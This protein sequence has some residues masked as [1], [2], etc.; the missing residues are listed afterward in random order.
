MQKTNKIYFLTI[1]LAS[2]LVISCTTTTPADTYSSELK[3]FSSEK[4]L[5]EFLKSSDYGGGY[6]GGIRTFAETAVDEAVSIAVPQAKAGGET[7]EDYSETNIQ[8]EG[9]DEA[10]IVKNDG[11]YIYVLTKNKIAIVDAYPA[12]DAEL[13]SEIEIKGNPR[14]FFI[15]KDKLIIFG[16][17]Y[18][19]QSRPVPFAEGIAVEK[20]AVEEDE[21][22]KLIPFPDY[23]SQ[24]AYAIIY[25]ISDKESPEEEEKII[26]RGNYYNSRMIGDT[27]YMIT[28]EYA[29]YR[30][31]IKPPCV[32][33]VKGETIRQR[34]I[35]APQIYYFDYPDSYEFSTIMAINLE[36]NSHK[37]KT[38]L[39]GTSQNMYVSKENIYITFQK[40][41]PY[42]Y[43]EM[44]I[45]EEVYMPILPNEL[46]QKIEKI[47]SYDISESSKFSEIRL[48]IEK[49]LYDM[50]EEEREKLEKQLQDKVEEVQRRI[51]KELEMTTVQKISID[52]MD[53][54]IWPS[55]EVPG[56][57]LNQFSMD[58]FDGYFRIATTNSQWNRERSANH[59]YVLDEYLDIVGKLEDL[60]P[61]ERIYSARFMG[62]R[63]YLV[64]FRNIDP[65]FVID[66][67][68]PENPSVLGKLKI[69]GY[70]DYLHPYDK[71]HI[72]G[73][74]KETVE[75]K[76]RDIAWQQGVKIALFDVSDVEKPKQLAK[77][78]IGDRGTDSY[79]LHDHKAF[80]FSRDKNLLVIPVTVAEIDEEK[81]PGGV[82]PQQYGDFVFQGAY[83]LDL[84][85]DGFEL[86]GKITHVED[87]D[88]FKKSGYYWRDSGEN[89]K[90]SLYMD[91]VLYTISD[92]KIKMNDL[93]DIDDEINEVKLPY[94]KKEYPAPRD[95]FIEEAVAVE[96]AE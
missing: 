29:H 4:E 9:V 7:A 63:L 23:T 64:T 56:R 91:D 70:S 22:A 18:K 86:K 67:E 65:L 85:L 75:D 12:E 41:M 94:E 40:R 38:I 60:A 24:Y 5:K 82:K 73:V 33:T 17:D 34:C 19:R 88:K 21:I 53:I 93:D 89:V 37:E 61:G 48:V 69:P 13:L 81:Y 59:V 26:L 74:G 45:I 84:D 51:Q 72:I 47:K 55:G 92:S 46:K 43:R 58:E 28:N 1:L 54:E 62:E 77:Y 2:I 78:E 25:D 11:K 16:T 79:A 49:W 96:A 66:L 20:T 90:R 83:V 95:V 8:V 71:D 6:A 68:D 76:D 87:P 50:P 52:E 32:Y 15:N 35:P 80:L 31:N 57:T 14:E 27:V 3:K 39:K 44:K 36:D 10:D 42:Y 30:W